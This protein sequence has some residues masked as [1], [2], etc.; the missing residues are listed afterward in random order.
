MRPRIPAR[1]ALLLAAALLVAAGATA[2]AIRLTSAQVV[3]V[4]LVATRPR[5]VGTAVTVSDVALVGNG[6]PLLAQRTAAVAQAPATTDLGVFSVPAGTYSGVVATV[7]GVRVSTSAR[8]VVQG[9][10]TPI[11][12]VVRPHGVEAAVGNDAANHAFLAAAGQLIHPPD[13]TFVDQTGRSVPLHSLRGKALVLAA[14]D[15]HCHETCPLYT[16]IW[17][18][19]QRVIRER[20]WQDRVAIAE[21][22]MDP[23]RETPDELAA[24]ARLVGSDW[25]LLRS[26][27]ASTRLF[28]TALGASAHEAPPPSPAPTDWYT[29]RPETYHLEH[30]SLAAVFDQNGDARY[31]LQG[32]PRLGHALTAPLAALLGGDTHA[33][34]LESTSSWDLTQLLDRIDVVL[35]VPG[36]VGRDVER[37]AHIGSPAPDFTLQDLGGRRVTLSSQLGHAVVVTFWMTWC[38]ACRRDFPRLAAA[39]RDHPGLTVIAVDEGESASRVRSFMHGVLGADASRL[40][41]LLDSDRTA[42]ARYAVSGM[43]TTMFVGAD[44]VLRVVRIGQFKGD[45]LETGLAS[46]GL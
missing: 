12:L 7:N 41:T 23:E 4:A 44:G 43:P 3:S 29:G 8:L 30:S 18:D 22:S 42:G 9:S 25:M 16:A 26:D 24:Y 1:L 5:T 13:V 32:N 35:G 19:L 38:D 6:A 34:A 2:L 14:L 28:W 36:E 39:V 20:G 37:A 11:A 10:L 45:D 17:S 15:T 33:Q 27:P 21:V 46:T 31:L 40:V